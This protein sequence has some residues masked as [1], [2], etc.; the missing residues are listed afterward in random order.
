MNMRCSVFFAI[1][2]CSVNGLRNL[3]V[4]NKNIA[5]DARYKSKSFDAIVD[6]FDVTIGSKFS[7]K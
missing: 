4:P 6:N 1:L 2:V 7:L 3:P 5:A